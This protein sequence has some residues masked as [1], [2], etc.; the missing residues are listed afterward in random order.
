MF[1]DWFKLKI[2]M[3][4]GVTLQGLFPRS[5][6]FPQT[7]SPVPQ[8]LAVEFSARNAM[9]GLGRLMGLINTPEKVSQI[10]LL[11]SVIL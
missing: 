6:W 4:H 5:S 11:I 9:L 2:Y 8:V 10:S 1:L 7:I 3:I